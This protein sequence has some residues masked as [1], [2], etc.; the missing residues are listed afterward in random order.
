MPEK[1]PFCCPEISC[2]KKFTSDS[3]RLKQ[4]KLHHPE[5]LQVALQKNL[6]VC[7]A[8]RR[9]E[10]AQRREFNA[11]ND[12]VKYLDAFPYLEHVENIADWES[13]PLPPP[14]PR[15]EIYPSAIASMSNFIAEL[16]E[17]DAQGCLETNEQN[18]PYYPVVTREEYNYIQCGIKK[19]GMKMYYENVLKKENTA[20]HFPSFKNWDDVQKLV[21]SMSDDQSVRE[22][23]L[24]TLQDMRWN[25]NHKR[26]IKYWSRDIIKSMG[27]L[28]W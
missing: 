8:P 23:E 26:P 27:W 20:L 14:L 11:Y 1:I 2:Q 5:H 28:M 25:D 24:H 17:C 3:W 10:P 16:R 21:A 13:Q 6:T 22:W 12:S 15:T 7:S 4:I 9:V 19:Q 18:N